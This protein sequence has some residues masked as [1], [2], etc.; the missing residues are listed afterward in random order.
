[1]VHADP[2]L[3]ERVV[4]NLI[5]NALRHG[6]GCSVVVRARA[7]A[8]GEAQ[9]QVSD[10]GPGLAADALDSLFTPFQRLGDRTSRPSG[11]S[12]NSW[13]VIAAPWFP[14]VDCSARYG[15]LLTEPKRTTCGSTSRNCAANS[16]HNR[17]VRVTSSPNPAWD[18]VF[19]INSPKGTQQKDDVTERPRHYFIPGTS[20]TPQVKEEGHEWIS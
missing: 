19:R 13:S 1:V 3:L 18:T 12:S 2:G 4:A 11:P 7:L 6:H 20:A 15:D 5:D 17:P 14:N 16:N 8:D 9:L 10:H